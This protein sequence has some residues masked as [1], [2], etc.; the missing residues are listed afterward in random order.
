[1]AGD[2]VG[3]A[4]MIRADIVGRAEDEVDRVVR[5]LIVE[6]GV[7]VDAGFVIVGVTV[8]KNSEGDDNCEGDIIAEVVPLFV[9]I[10]DRVEDADCECSVIVDVAVPVVVS[11]G[12]AVKWEDTENFEE[13]DSVFVTGSV[14]A[15]VTSGDALG[16]ALPLA[17]KD[18]C[19]E[20]ETEDEVNA[21]IDSYAE[22]L[23]LALA[24][25]EYDSREEDDAESVVKAETLEDSLH[26]T[27]GESK[28]DGDVEADADELAELEVEALLVELPDDEGLPKEDCE[29]EEVIDDE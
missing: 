13:R 17:D 29:L 6:C 8:L 5:A 4:V 18:S 12:T 3:V 23:A 20:K 2:G 24:D 10:D 16:K 11:V 1:M 19:A 9:P 15:R 25:G 28:Y 27:D 22:K 7:L 26:V 14:G 21:L